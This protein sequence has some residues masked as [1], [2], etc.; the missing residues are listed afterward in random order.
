MEKRR[1]PFG[2][3]VFLTQHS[4]LFAEKHGDFDFFQ[5]ASRLYCY[6]CF[7]KGRS[8]GAASFF[9]VQVIRSDPGEYSHK[10]M[11]CRTPKLNEYFCLI[12]R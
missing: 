5:T 3:Q 1:D 6:N 11:I 2:F 9:V 8:L 10:I 7:E 4:P 12:M